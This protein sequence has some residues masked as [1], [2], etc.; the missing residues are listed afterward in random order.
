MTVLFVTQLVPSTTY[1]L[2]EE[3]RALVYDALID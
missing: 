1:P 3:L 2:R